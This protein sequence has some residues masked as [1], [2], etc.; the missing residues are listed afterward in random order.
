MIRVLVTGSRDW[1][2]YSLIAREVVLYISEV[3]PVEF[4]TPNEL[5]VDWDTHDLLVVHGDAATGADYIVEEFA[6]ANY[7]KTEKHHPDYQQ[8]GRG[9][10]QVR[11][12]HMVQLGADVC[13]AFIK[14]CTY[15]PGRC[16]I[17]IPHGSHGASRTARL[18]EQAGI[19]TRRFHEGWNPDENPRTGRAARSARRN[20]G[21]VSD[22]QS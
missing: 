15:P 12:Q 10:P 4:A 13:L 18:A 5:E 11:N 22:R 3:C 16:N 9:A 17:R 21:G 2:N 6:A 7:I 1:T 19:E 20:H 8:Y 14:P